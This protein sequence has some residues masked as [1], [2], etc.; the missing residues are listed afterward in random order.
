VSRGGGYIPKIVVKGGRA[1][2]TAV[3]A[4][5]AATGAAA[6]AGAAAATIPYFTYI[7]VFYVHYVG[8]F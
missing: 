5:A 6:E 2:G 8:V 4:G 7:F 3:A 1:A